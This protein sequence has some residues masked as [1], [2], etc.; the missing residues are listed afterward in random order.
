MILKYVDD[1]MKIILQIV[2]PF[3]FYLTP[4][5]YLL[6]VYKNLR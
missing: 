6:I 5:V 4:F 1:F 3:L 2:L